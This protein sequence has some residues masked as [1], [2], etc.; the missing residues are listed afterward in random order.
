[1]ADYL[2][3]FTHTRYVG[4]GWDDCFETVLVKGCDSFEEAVDVIKSHSYDNPRN[5][6]DL[7]LE[8]AVPAKPPAQP[9]LER[10]E[11]FVEWL[12]SEGLHHFAISDGAMRAMYDVWNRMEK[13]LADALRT[14]SKLAKCDC[15]RLLSA[16]KCRIC[17]NDEQEKRDGA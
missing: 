16:G 2:V 17:D 8:P 12:K 9:D 13:R 4:G 10:Q 1:M 6:E 5:F 3:R 11:E 7:T 14:W 15:G